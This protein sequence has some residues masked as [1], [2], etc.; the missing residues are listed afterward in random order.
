MHIY[1][2]LEQHNKE[3]RIDYYQ[4]KNHVQ[5]LQVTN[6]V[7]RLLTK[8]HNNPDY[9]FLLNESFFD[10]VRYSI[11]GEVF[12]PLRID[13]LNNLIENKIQEAKKEY[14]IHGQ[15]LLYDIDHISVNGEAAD[16]LL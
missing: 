1:Y 15:I 16:Y 8:H 9:V 3:Q 10:L 11:E 14:M 6:E 5:K 4:F 2:P 12:E 7:E 13:Q